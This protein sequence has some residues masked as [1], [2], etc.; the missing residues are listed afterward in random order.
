MQNV[1][2]SVALAW[3]RPAAAAVPGL[4]A[5][6]LLGVSLW[7]MASGAAAQPA[8]G[9]YGRFVFGPQPGKAVAPWWPTSLSPGGRPGATRGFR[10]G[11]GGGAGGFLAPAYPSGAGYLVVSQADPGLALVLGAGLSGADLAQDPWP[12]HLSP[13]PAPQGQLRAGLSQQHGD[14]SVFYGMTWIGRELSGW[15]SSRLLGALHLQLR[16]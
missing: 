15:P 7:A 11:D 9:D 10:D 16:F 2:R 5:G 3:A 14:L 13:Q 12:G 4:L 1:Q 6:L 8:D